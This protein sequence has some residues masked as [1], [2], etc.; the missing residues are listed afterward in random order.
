M[1]VTLI[2]GCSV[3]PSIPTPT[4]PPAPAPTPTAIPTPTPKPASTPTLVHTATAV[5]TPTPKP[6]ATPTLVHTATAVPTPIPTVVPTPTPTATPTPTP[7]PASTPTPTPIPTA[8]PVPRAALPPPIWVIA[9]EVSPEDEAL[10]RDEMEVVR[11]YFRDGHGFEATGF[12]VILAADYEALVAAH[13]DI[14]GYAPSRF[15]SR[16]FV[17]NSKAGGAVLVLSYHV[18]LYSSTDSLRSAISHEYV[19]VLQGQLA[20]GFELLPNGEIASNRSSSSLYWMV[21]GAA[22]YLA[23]YKYSSTRPG[24]R[25]F[26]DRFSPYKDLKCEPQYEGRDILENLALELERIEDYGEFNRSSA[27]FHSYSLS[28]VASVFLIEE[29]GI[30][31]GSYLNYWKLLGEIDENSTGTFAEAFG[32]STNDFYPAFGEWIHS[33]VIDKRIFHRGSCPTLVVSNATT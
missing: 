23:N 20:S 28:F 26:S 3:E 30:K 33:G 10:L 15:A 9:G 19:H 32:M 13:Q 12:T 27:G 1:L 17:T 22:A 2:S 21:E 4:L 24:T 14:V 7:T 29:L 25:P 16:A 8:T 5:P 11:A 18:P 31:E 6:A